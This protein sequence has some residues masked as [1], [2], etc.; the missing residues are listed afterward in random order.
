MTKKSV[1]FLIILYFFYLFP[2]KV[3]GQSLQ[4]YEDKLKNLFIEL[5]LQ[6]TD[7]AID[8]VNNLILPVF[9]RALNSEEAFSYDFEKLDNISKLISDNYKLKIYNWNV[10]YKNGTFKYFGFLHYKLNK[11]E[12]KVIELFDKSEEIEKPE[13]KVLNSKNWYGAFYFKII[14]KKYKGVVYYTLLGW[15][16]NDIFTNKKL[17]ETLSF[18]E[19]GM[20][21]FGVPILSF[22]ERK[23]NRV[24]FEFTEQASMLLRF[25]E[26]EN[27]IVWDRLAPSKKELE[28]NPIYYGPSFIY[29]GLSFEKGLWIFYDDLDMKNEKEDKSEKNLKY[30]Y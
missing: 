24:I 5:R 12:F 6:K 14:V 27:M 3:S 16:G 2:I 15:D 1:G 23:Q 20:P 26:K 30:G 8:S 11:T 19:E 9:K 28:G 25:D 21:T 10:Q 13:N 17:I 22:K 29:D 7:A 4:E 18:S